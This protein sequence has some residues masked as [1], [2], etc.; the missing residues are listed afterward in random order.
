MELGM[1]VQV[2]YP[3]Y[4]EGLTGTIVALEKKSGRWLVKLEENHE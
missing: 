2:M 1:V 4:A 3:W